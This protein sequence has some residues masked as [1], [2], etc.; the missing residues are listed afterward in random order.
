MDYN[1]DFVMQAATAWDLSLTSL[2]MVASGAPVLSQ[3]CTLSYSVLL[4]DSHAVCALHVK[5]VSHHPTAHAY[6]LHKFT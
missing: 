2:S 3:A 5:R 6:M 4:C 1:F